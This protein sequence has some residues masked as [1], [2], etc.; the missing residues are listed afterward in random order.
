[1]SAEPLAILEVDGL[2]LLNYFLLVE[3]LILVFEGR[4]VAAQ[5]E[6]RLLEVRAKSLPHLRIEALIV[7]F[8][9]VCPLFLILGCGRV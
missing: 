5:A 7:T 1:M 8:L 3:E 9:N 2:R 6:L 4:D